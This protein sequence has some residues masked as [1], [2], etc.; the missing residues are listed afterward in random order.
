[1]RLRRSLSYLYSYKYITFTFPAQYIHGSSLD[2]HLVLL[3]IPFPQTNPFLATS[4]LSLPLSVTKGISDTSTN[5]I[6]TSKRHSR[7]PRQPSGS[8]LTAHPRTKT[9]AC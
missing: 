5:N 3:L 9:G 4:L 1:M 6:N 2:H 8:Q 7:T